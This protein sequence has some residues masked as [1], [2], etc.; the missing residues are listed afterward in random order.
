MEE[1]KRLLKRLAEED[2][3]FL[4]GVL[5]EAIGDSGAEELVETLLRSPRARARLAAEL[6]A[7]ITI[8]LNVATKE[9]IKMLETKMATKEDLRALE[10]R[11]ATKDD[12]KALE[13]RMATKEDLERFATKEDLQRFATREDV[14]VV[15]EEVRRLE[16]S[17]AT[18]EDLKALEARMA[19]KEDL[20]KFATKED[21]ERFATKED[22]RR[23]ENKM[24]TKEQVED[25]ALSLEEVARDYV[26]WFLKQRGVLCRA[27]R[28]RL[29]GEYEFDVYCAAGGVTVVG[30]VKLRASAGA[31]ERLVA[32]VEEAV[33]MWPEKFQGRVVK[34]FYCMDASPEAVE[35]ARE[36][37]VW[38]IEASRELTPLPL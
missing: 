6:A 22:I 18:K 13:A 5:L 29:D 9:D 36:L 38:L 25:I 26:V 31:V 24:A 4:R 7:M 8:P 10:A 21:L 11:M 14:A 34:V 28:L 35:K 2:R 12:I 20:Q 30:E 27:S 1:F 19:T 23:L 17:M 16:E 37:G 33:R 15:R 3:E 32:R